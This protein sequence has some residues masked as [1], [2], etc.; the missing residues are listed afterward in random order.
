[1]FYKGSPI[2]IHYKLEIR[3]YIEKKLMVKQYKLEKRYPVFDIKKSEEMPSNLLPPSPQNTNSTSRPVEE[4]KPQ[5][6]KQPAPENPKTSAPSKPQQPK[7]EAM[8][9]EEPKQAQASSSGI[10]HPLA[11]DVRVLSKAGFAEYLGQLKTAKPAAEK[12]GIEIKDLIEFEKTSF[13]VKYL[14]IYLEELEK[15]QEEF[16]NGKTV[17]TES[18]NKCRDLMLELTKRKGQVERNVSS[19]K[20]TPD[21]YLEVLKNE[22]DNLLSQA[23]FVK[24]Y[25]K[26]THVFKFMFAKAQIM[27]SEIKELEEFLK[28][29]N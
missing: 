24:K 21:E 9:E 23:K 26:N 22:F 13:S 5:P 10:T 29:P 18:V 14:T 17:D 20:L 16:I 7:E 6:S 1:M 12:A 25:V 8:D 3:R 15:Q 28:N 11:K 19:G 2:H 27:D 4:S